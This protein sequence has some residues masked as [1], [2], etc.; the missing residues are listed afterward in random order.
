MNPAESVLRSSVRLFVCSLVV[1]ER[2]A[3]GVW[4]AQI[5]CAH[6]APPSQSTLTRLA[7]WHFSV[8]KACF[9][10]RSCS[11]SAL[12]CSVSPLRISSPPR[13]TA[14]Q[15]GSVAVGACSLA[16]L[17]AGL[18]RWFASSFARSSKCS[19]EASLTPLPQSHAQSFPVPVFVLQAL[20][21]ALYAFLTSCTV[22]VSTAY[23]GT[24]PSMPS[25]AGV[26]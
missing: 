24:V 9:P 23:A 21:D 1:R 26:Q 7:M 25:Y 6:I 12:Q 17:L 22:H 14:I 18:A 15:Q 20:R 2:T 10:L 4:T 11:A 3:H 19:N 5:S 8:R 13:W 16:G